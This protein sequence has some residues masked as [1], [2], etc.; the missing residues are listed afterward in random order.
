MIKD[1]IVARELHEDG[2][3]HI[4]AWILL[5]K[6]VNIG[7]PTIFDIDGSH[8]NMQGAKSNIAVMKYVTKDGDYISTI[9]EADLEAM[10]KGRG[11]HKQILG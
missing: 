8:P 4:H 2:N 6:K 10:K 7:D 1:Y 11:Q 5:D 3:P 9:S